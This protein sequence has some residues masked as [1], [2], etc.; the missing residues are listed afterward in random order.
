M[1]VRVGTTP[2][3]WLQ[4]PEPLG[5][6]DSGSAHFLSEVHVQFCLSHKSKHVRAGGGEEELSAGGEQ[7]T[8]VTSSGQHQGAFPQWLRWTGLGSGKGETCWA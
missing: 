3:L 7:D 8:E 1:T 2:R 4:T 5:L 6:V